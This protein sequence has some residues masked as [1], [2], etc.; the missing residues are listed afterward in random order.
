VVAGVSLAL[1]GVFL[2]A[3]ARGFLNEES[4][5]PPW[6]M[7]LRSLSVG[8]VFL[9][10]IPIAFYWDADLAKY[11]WLILIPLGFAERHLSQTS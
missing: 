9:V 1:S 6:K 7:L 8:T 11:F 4:Q 3:R 2:Y 10:S 5:N